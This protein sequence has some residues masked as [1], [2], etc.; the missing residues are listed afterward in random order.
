MRVR[1]NLAVDVTLA[2]G[3]SVQNGW[4]IRPDG[5]PLFPVLAFEV[6]AAGEPLIGSEAAMGK[7]GITDLCYDLCETIV[8]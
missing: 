4:V 7:S 5:T 8:T 3:F 2:D 6:D 1:I